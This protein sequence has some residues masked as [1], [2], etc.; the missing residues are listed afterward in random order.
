MRHPGSTGPWRS[1]AMWPEFPPTR[2]RPPRGSLV[3]PSG[4]CRR[5]HIPTTALDHRSARRC[6]RSRVDHLRRTRSGSVTSL[7]DPP[8]RFIQLKG[9]NGRRV[10]IVED[11]VVRLLATTESIYP[12]AQAALQSGVTLAQAAAAVAGGELLRYDEIHAG[13]SPWQVLLRL[14]CCCQTTKCDGL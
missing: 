2:S 12:L 10:R 14:N 4:L 9:P 3:V 1:S 7:S 11:A 8:M 13:A 6:P 5:T